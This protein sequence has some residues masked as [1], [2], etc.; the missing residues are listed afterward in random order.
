M[1]GPAEGLQVGIVEPQVGTPCDALD[2]VDQRSRSGHAFLGAKAAIGFGR[3]MLSAEL[4][5][6]FAVTPVACAWTLAFIE[7]CELSP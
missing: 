2:V 3:K 4:L 7:A 5:P 6:I 1:A